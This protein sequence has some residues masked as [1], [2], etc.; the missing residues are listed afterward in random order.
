M[1]RICKMKEQRTSEGCTGQ[2]ST[3]KVS[4]SYTENR[5]VTEKISSPSPCHTPH[6]S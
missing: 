6:S 2:L 4:L 3:R 1:G 5:N